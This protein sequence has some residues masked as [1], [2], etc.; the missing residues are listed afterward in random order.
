MIIDS[1][2]VRYSQ[3]NIS[4]SICIPT[5]NRPEA[6]SNLLSHL[7][8]QI[9]DR[10]EIVVRDDSP[11]DN[12]KKI[13]HSLVNNTKINYKYF[14]DSKI[15][16][17][18]ASLFLLEN[19]S[20]DYVW[21]FGDD[22]ELLDGGI[23][24]VLNLM[25]NNND[26]NFIWANFALGDKSNL[27]VD[28][29][30]GFFESQDDML[31]SLGNSIGLISAAIV[32]RKVALKG[33]ERAQKHIHGFSWAALAIALYAASEPGRSYFLRGPFILCNPTTIDE[34]KSITVKGVDIDNDGFITY[35][36]YFLELLEDFKDRFSAKSIR[37]ILT[38]N[39]SSL[40]RGMLVG[41]VGGWDTPKGKRISLL[42]YY[43]SYPEF[44]VA[45]PIM[46]LPRWMVIALYKFYKI[47]YS[48]RK[49]IF[50]KNKLPR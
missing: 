31:E 48:H 22:D 16:L 15:G 37:K 14:H 24:A 28:R 19:A 33:L 39:F 50:L 34:I 42:K 38:V 12:S 27:A 3:H 9:D 43:W 40:W 44:W 20:G 32:K 41:W 17:D 23:K 46:L 2:V 49:F 13:F 18:A 7:L 10:V 21:W 6:F 11:N 25:D 45:F 47:F 26:L 36:I 8:P 30:A 5:Y 4:L 1:S 35:G 29:S